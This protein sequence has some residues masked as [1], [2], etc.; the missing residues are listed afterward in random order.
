MDAFPFP[1]AIKILM[2][3]KSSTSDAD[4]LHQNNLNPKYFLFQDSWSGKT[5]FT[6]MGQ[7]NVQWANRFI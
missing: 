6:Y 2:L 4:K 3:G 7:L 1:A 5:G